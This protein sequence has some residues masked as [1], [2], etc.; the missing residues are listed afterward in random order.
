MFVSHAL[1]LEVA[2]PV[3]KEQGLRILASH[4]Q[5]KSSL[6]PTVEIHT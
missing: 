4:R 5:S 3:P 2:L 6:F 1:S